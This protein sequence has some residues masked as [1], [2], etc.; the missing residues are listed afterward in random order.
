[1]TTSVF[2]SLL[3]CTAGRWLLKF[4]ADCILALSTG[5]HKDQQPCTL[6]ANARCLDEPYGLFLISTALSVSMFSN[7]QCYSVP[8]LETR[9]EVAQ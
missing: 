8:V 4:W 9:L 3:Q 1:M 6:T 5:Y 2:E 7:V